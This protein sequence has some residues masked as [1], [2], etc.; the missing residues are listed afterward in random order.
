[1]FEC[2]VNISEGADDT[3]LARIRSAAGSACLDVHTD[4][5]HHRSVLTLADPE[6]DTVTAAAQ[7]LT[8]SATE[9]LD[10]ADHAGVHPRFGAIDVVPFVA[11]SDTPA[12]RDAAADAARAYAQWAA[13]TFAVPTF[14]YDAADPLGRSLPDVRRDAFTA[15]EPDFGP[16][17]PHAQLGA[18]AV[19]ARA[20][21]VA[22]NVELATA[23]LAVA[24]RIART[25]RAS[26]GGLAGVRALG[27][28]LP[29]RAT[30]QVS[31]NLVDLAATGMEAA[32][33]AVAEHARS[34]G[35]AV[36]RVE[37]VGLV[38]HAEFAAWSPWFR[39][40]TG[41]DERITVEGRIALAGRNAD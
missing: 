11:L 20:P 15:R 35:V 2:V 1:M 27:F 24:Q 10:L 40:W 33:G 31:M 34:D 25:V 18:I 41:Y 5:D 28:P 16:T 13:A 39:E 36:E 8:R 4:P 12:D 29:T 19:G 32:C 9:Y 37:L 22:V 6:L 38:P 23:D 7:A 21:M 26:N 3:V 14:L 30:V 17:E